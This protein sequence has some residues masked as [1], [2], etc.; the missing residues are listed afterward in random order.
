MSVVSFGTCFITKALHIVG[1]PS[2]IELL[3]VLINILDP[4]DQLHTDSTRLAALGILSATFEEA[5]SRFGAFPSLTA[6]IVDPGCKF[7]FQLA[8]SDHPAVLQAAL[9]VISSV[10]FTMR[11]HLKLQ[12]ELFLAFTMDRLAYI[13]QQ[14]NRGRPGAMSPRPGTP[15]PPA[16]GDEKEKSVTPQ[17]VIIS[18]AKGETRD[19]LLETL[20]Q[21]SRYPSFM[22]DLYANYDC[23]IN[24]ENLFERLVDFLT[25]VS[26]W[27]LAHYELSLKS[28]REFIQQTT[29]A[30]WSLSNKI[31]SCYA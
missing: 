29:L 16:E 28:S 23:D 9:R 31:R 2:I 25:A 13:P 1:L 11:P 3:R 12:Q 30:V 26:G 18:P 8:R 4:S 27:E 19:L 6:L 17:R 10:F 15:Q 22:V 7:L 14:P 20:S 5:G 24:C 21:I